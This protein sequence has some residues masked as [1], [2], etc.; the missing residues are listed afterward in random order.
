MSG[1][2]CS[3]CGVDL[4]RINGIDTTTALKVISEVGPDLSRFKSAKHFTSWLGCAGNEDFRGKILSAPASAPPTGRPRPC[5]WLPRFCVPA[6]LP[7]RLL[8]SPVRLSRSPKAIT[9]TTHKLARLIYTMLTKGTEYT[10]QG[11]DY[12][13]ERYRQRVMH[14]LAKRAEKPASTHPLAVTT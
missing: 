7:W 4:T 13:E 5:G 9:P 12:Y 6:S 10:D 1:P 11:Q 3:G 2:I 14:H 8:P